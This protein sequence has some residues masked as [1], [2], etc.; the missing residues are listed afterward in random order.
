MAIEVLLRRELVASQAKIATEYIRYIFMLQIIYLL[1][2]MTAADNKKK[3]MEFIW[4]TVIK[5]IVLF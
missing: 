2:L 5:F 1:F 4:R 3:W